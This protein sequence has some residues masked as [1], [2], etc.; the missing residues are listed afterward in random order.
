MNGN[1]SNT[2]IWRCAKCSYHFANI[3]KIEGVIQE[4]K[5]CPKCKSLNILTMTGK[6]TINKCKF[7]DPNTNGYNENG[8]YENDY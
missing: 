4:E 7:H 3:S 1:S 5:K 2:Y 8:Y 6:E